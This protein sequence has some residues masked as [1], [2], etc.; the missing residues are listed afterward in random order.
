VANVVIDV[1][2]AHIVDIRK[3]VWKMINSSFKE[4]LPAIIYNIWLWAMF[5]TCFPTTVVY[6]SSLDDKII[7]YICIKHSNVHKHMLIADT[8]WILW[9]ETITIG[10][11][12]GGIISMIIKNELHGSLIKSYSKTFYLA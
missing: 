7:K 6:F 9:D 2:V 1:K 12:T 8:K 4:W 5:S 11:R 3:S 10:M